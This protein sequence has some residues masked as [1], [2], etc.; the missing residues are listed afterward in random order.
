MSAGR[1][2]PTHDPEKLRRWHHEDG[3]ALKEIAERLGCAPA[4]VGAWMRAAG[5]EVQRKKSPWGAAAG[6]GCRLRLGK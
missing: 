2:K 3:L 4:T 6:T 5:I 1:P